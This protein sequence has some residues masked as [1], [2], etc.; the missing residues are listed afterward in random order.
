MSSSQTESLITLSGSV[1]DAQTN[2]PLE[3][4]TISIHHA[5]ND[6]I[7]A[8]TSTNK[9]G[10]FRFSIPIGTY[11]LKV[12]FLSFKLYELKSKLFNDNLNL[13]VITLQSDDRLEE[14]EVVAEKNLFET[15]FNKRIYNASIDIAN[16]GGNAI[17]VLNN[18]PTVRVDDEG[19][20]IVRGGSATLLID[21]KPQFGI[22]NISTMLKALP[23]NVIDRVEIITRSAKYSAD[24]AGG[25]VLNIITKK[26]QGLG[27]NG[28][29][30]VHGGI[31]DN[32]GFS[33]FINEDTEKMNLYSTISFNHEDRNK[34][35]DI[36]QGSLNFDQK[37]LDKR[38]K[39]GLLFNLGSDFYL[40]DKNTLSA[41]FLINATNKNFRSNL[42]EPDFTRNVNDSEDASRIEVA[43]GNK[44]KFNEDGHELSLNVT[45]SNTDSDGNSKITENRT[46]ESIFQKS[47]KD[48]KLDNLLA[49]F[50]YKLPLNEKSTIE[51]GYQ[52][53]FRFYNNDFNVSEFD[54]SINDFVTVGNLDDEI[55]YDEG[56]HAF[57]GLY[58]G[59][60]NKFSYSIGLRTEITDITLQQQ[61]LSEVK[62]NY[63]D[64]FPSVI[65]GYEISEDGYLSLN[66]SRSIDRP[67]AA[68]INPF[69]TFTDERFQT[70]GNQDLNPFYTNYLELLFDHSFDKLSLASS[71]FLNFASDQ[72]LSV[73]QNTG[74]QTSDG[75]DIFRRTTINSGDK[76]ILGIDL[77]VTYAIS[78]NFSLN[79]YIS[80]Y[81]Q[82][83]S[84]AIDQDYNN[85]NT[86]WYASGR[87]TLS[88]NNGFR[89]RAD[90]IYQSPIKNGLTELRTINFS[91]VS[92]SKDLFKKKARLT[93]RINDIFSSKKFKYESFEANTLTF[94][95]V[96]FE[97]QYL[98]TFT[99]RFNQKGRNAK[100]RSK[101]INKDDLE[102]NQD[103]KL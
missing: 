41:S 51:L 40:D 48:Q 27:T 24:G 74:Q 5:I 99:Y 81:F 21:G 55:G 34:Y 6:S 92:L 3:Y 16:L 103:K 70:V 96:R 77:D 68:Q 72:F 9:Q 49:Q 30:E 101:D 28:S 2:E 53:T 89:V 18:T 38:Q 66:Y 11:T 47:L 50:D 14:V 59:S 33:S 19:L 42:E 91:N 65:L 25:A 58:N 84:N 44:T 80:P 20:V 1:R 26:R 22:D 56:V 64:L 31:P 37:R 39:N 97:N 95:D 93:F 13:G 60:A 102:D 87:A 54:P 85:E 29:V 98:L 4:A 79:A 57:Y 35:T 8:G 69:I 10:K 83:I 12:Q 100:N 76:N 43:L 75:Q 52:G 45:Y 73:I 23:S 67:T 36:K 17:D 86:I 7:V 90:H 32:H 62:K 71:F 82:K 46:T 88:L 94:R 78:K 61:G 15:K 63:S